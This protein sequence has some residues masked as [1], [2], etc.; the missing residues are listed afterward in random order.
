M[1]IIQTI[2]DKAA[3]MLIAAI[4]IALIAFILQDAFSGGGGMTGPTDVGS[5]DGKK[6]SAVDFEQRYNQ[7][8]NQYRNAGYPLNDVLRQ[9]IRE[10]IWEGYLQDVVFEEKYKQLG[11]EVTNNELSDILY[12]ANP[13]Q[14]LRQ[15][16]TDPNTG[17]YDA[18]AAYEQI[19]A[20]S[21]QKNTNPAMYQGFF[22]EYIPSLKD[23]RKQEK[24]ISL[25]SKSAYVPKWLVEKIS[26]DN[27][28]AA[29]IS[30][31]L[32]P[33]N[34]I[35][36]SLVTVTDKEITDFIKKYP[37][38]YKQEEARGIEYVMFDAAASV[39]DSNA[40]K[41]QLEALKDEFATD[42]D[43]T[44]FL[45]RNGSEV[46]F[47]DG[48]IQSSKIQV[49]EAENIKSL[50]EN[51]VYGPYLDQ[52]NYVLAKMIG[53]RSIPDSV[54]VR[55]ILIKTA[56]Q[57]LVTLDDSTAKAR[58]DSVVNA[59][60]G[61]A[62]FSAMVA[63]YS[64]D[65]G[66]LQTNGEYDFTSVQFGNLSREFAEVAFYGK[67]GDKKIVNVSNA[68]YSGYHYIEVLSQKN[69]EPAYNIAYLSLPILP[70]DQTINAALGKAT[71]FAGEVKDKKTFDAAAEK[72]GY[73][74]FNAY[75]IKPLESYVLGLGSSRE[76]V[77]WIYNSKVGAVSDQPIEVEDKFVVPILTRAYSE[78]LMPADMARPLVE[79]TLLNKKKAEIIKK[80]IG[81]PT[82]L[83][84]VA[85]ATGQPVQQSDSLTFASTFIP[86]VG[87]EIAVVGAA[88]NKKYEEQPSEAITGNAGVFVI[89]TNNVYAIPNPAFDVVN[90]Q[91]TMLTFQE[92][93]L[94]D[95]RTILD[96]LKKE[97][98]IKD[99]RRE[100]F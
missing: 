45:L 94:S 63:A 16:F 41:N 34:T 93:A 71:Q 39:E 29:S 44:A 9:N 6:I 11:L 33:Y 18:N 83:E 84:A 38:D 50:N 13:P 17:Q 82:T 31:V 80:N 81:N 65:P 35:S 48:Y 92:R 2:R 51:E 42:N 5:I 58:M 100:F 52:G 90:Q 10:S 46:D 54:K 1:S 49:P 15:Q 88:F 8:E 70:S 73:N 75:D 89:K 36:D 96:I 22:N 76:L 14:D 28:L 86:N 30:Y 43:P 37:E 67:T 78:G 53:K 23:A 95:P 12:G 99:N 69:F 85:Q 74:K 19:L 79:A 21:K 72:Y 47:F 87:Q 56:D 97:I 77:R 68:S 59:I 62:S 24:Y 25:I 4:A 66:S 3:W 27:S 57:G 7:I 32:V 64:E 61:G 55:H 26:L 98:K 60:R 40:V 20:L 91:A